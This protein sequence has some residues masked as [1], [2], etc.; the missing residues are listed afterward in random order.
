MAGRACC[1]IALSEERV[2]QLIAH[3]DPFLLIRHAVENVIGVQVVAVARQNSKLDAPTPFLMLEGMAQ[4][5]AVLIR[6]MPMYADRRLVSLAGL[7]NVRWM[8]NEDGNGQVL[9]T[10]RISGRARKRFGT[11]NAQAHCDGETL[12]VADFLFSFIEDAE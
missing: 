2:K 8:A 9:Y 11:V 5:G 7:Q 6:Q 12:C 3:R 1:R 10:A 4:T